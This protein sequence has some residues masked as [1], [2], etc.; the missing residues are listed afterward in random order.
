MTKIQ[1]QLES[2]IKEMLN[3]TGV[4]LENKVYTSLV[5]HPQ[6]LA[7]REEPYSQ[8]G[9]AAELIEGTIDVFAVAPLS[10]DNAL[11][12]LLECKKA[13][14]EQKHW[15]FER[16]P[17]EDE[18]LWYPF[19]FFDKS[20]GHV[21]YEK[22]IFFPSLGYDGMSSFDKAIQ[23]FEFNERSGGLNRNSRERAYNAIRQANEAL[24]GFNPNE[25][26]QRV[27]ELLP[28][29]DSINILYL[30]IVIT[31]ANLWVMEYKPEDV[32]WGT[33]TLSIDELSL[34]SKGWIIYE[35]PLPTNFQIRGGNTGLQI[36]RPTF[37]VNA[38]KFGT[39]IDTLFKDCG[40]YIL[41]FK[42]KV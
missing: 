20:L 29:A 39:F 31:T 32:E 33:G 13:N 36:K 14:P 5:R 22:N 4:F 41:D 30:S 18:P 10:K 34:T 3:N 25:D 42:E 35:F 24:S 12:L 2:S 40:R 11:C 17:V 1:K 7:R 26:I 16:R 15:V 38:E 6:F 37:V 27:I 19:V 21:N 8:L 28:T 23:V 9:L